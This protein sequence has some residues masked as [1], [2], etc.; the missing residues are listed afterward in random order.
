MTVSAPTS[1]SIDTGLPNVPELVTDPATYR[2]LML[3]YRA[4]KNLQASS[5]AGLSS[6]VTA[7]MLPSRKNLVINGAFDISQY[8]YNSAVTPLGAATYIAD[9][10]QT[11]FSQNSK[12]TFQRVADAPA[13]FKYSMKVTVAVQASLAAGDYFVLTN[14]LEGQEIISAG[15][16]LAAAAQVAVT[17][18]VKGSVAGNYACALRNGAGTRSYLGQIAVTTTWAKQTIILTADT[19]G[20]W[21]T[22]NTLGLAF[23]IDLGSGSTLQGTVNTWQTGNKVSVAGGVMF[24]TQAAGATLNIVGLQIRPVPVGTTVAPPDEY[25]SPALQLRRCQRYCETTYA[26]GVLFGT[27]T[28]AGAW[29]AVCIN[30]A[31]FYN[32]GWF[33]YKVVK[34]ASPTV[35][36]YSSLDGAAGYFSRLDAANIPAGVASASTTTARFNCSSGIAGYYVR[37]N[38]TIRSEL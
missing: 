27:A 23:S 8:N 13:G 37:G 19:T 21:A 7:A 15:F 4:I 34:R 24:A 14:L 5:A 22:D 38:I 20:T 16:G 36:V 31:D 11:L 33:T 17:L 25:E 18:W 12:L 9:M 2:E 10:W 35:T 26:E 6:A 3:I 32:F 29:V 1:N 30:G 28:Q